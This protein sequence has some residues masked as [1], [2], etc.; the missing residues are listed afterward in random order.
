[1]TGRQHDLRSIVDYI[2]RQVQANNCNTNQRRTRLDC[3]ICDDTKRHFYLYLSNFT[4][5]CFRCGAHFNLRGI[6]TLVDLRLLKLASTHS[7][8]PDRKFK[9]P[10]DGWDAVPVCPITRHNPGVDSVAHQVYWRCIDRGVTAQQIEQYVVSV[11]PWVPR[12]YFPVWDDCGDLVYWCSRTLLDEEPR[13]DS[14]QDST[15]PLYG[16]HVQRY[17]DQVILVEGVF[18]HFVTRQSYG[19]LGPSVTEQQVTVLK[20]DGVRRIFVVGDLDARTKAHES[21]RVLAEQGMQSYPVHLPTS[22]GKKDPSDYGRAAMSGVVTQLLGLGP[23]RPQTLCVELPQCPAATGSDGE[24]RGTAR[25][26]PAAEHRVPARPRRRPRD[27][28][29]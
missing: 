29:G 17:T 19:I 4:A 16:R 23:L 13:M 11:R 27:E 26:T 25:G 9:V 21:A 20:Q 14:M 28:P 2:R 7:A 8:T 1:M 15:R 3:P 5:H 22:G 12:A 6:L 10:F 18:D 24:R